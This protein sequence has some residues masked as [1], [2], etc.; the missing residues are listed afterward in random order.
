[1]GE[2]GQLRGKTSSKLARKV[3]YCGKIED[4]QV[5]LARV[6]VA[7]SFGVPIPEL[8]APTRRTAN[9]AR[10]RQVAMYLC[11]VVFGINLTRVGEL[12]GRDRTTASYACALVEDRRDDPGFD[13]EV[14][15][16][17]YALKSV[18]FAF[19]IGP[20]R[21]GAAPRGEKGQRARARI[22]A[23]REGRR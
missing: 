6:V 8:Q 13:R 17:E 12:F 4:T 9:V 7:T 11:H 18:P 5:A 19:G 3:S 16:L 14:E 21:R 15:R 23:R 10:A 22:A 1:M 2:I 20:Q